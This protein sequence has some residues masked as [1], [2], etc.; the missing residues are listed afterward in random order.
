MSKKKSTSSGLRSCV[1]LDR[2][3]CLI[4]EVD[5]LTRPEQVRI[6]YGSATAVRKLNEAGLLAIVVSNQSG[7]ARGLLTEE[8]LAR[9]HARLRAK[10][11]RRNAHLDGIYYCPFLKQA[12]VKQYRQDSPLRKPRPGMV[13]LAAREHPVDLSRSYVVGDKNSDVELGKNCGLK[14]VMVLTGYGPKELGKRRS[15]GLEP[16][17]FI[18]TNLA[19]AVA[20]ILQDLKISE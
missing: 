6:I 15:A 12:K 4:E 13:E 17:D 10:L 16:P 1:F 18:A 9:I 2:D 11:A 7:V 8:T 3:G 19:Q 14:T 20:W 5:Y